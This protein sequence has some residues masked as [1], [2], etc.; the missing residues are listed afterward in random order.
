MR[1]I[2]ALAAPAIGLAVLTLAAAPSWAADCAFEARVWASVSSSY[3]NGAR[4][5]DRYKD[6]KTGQPGRVITLFRSPPALKLIADPAVFGDPSWPETQ[7]LV[8]AL[9]ARLRIEHA[10]LTDK[11]R[12]LSSRAKLCN[13]DYDALTASWRPAWQAWASAASALNERKSAE[14]RATAR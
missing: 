1:S 9:N 7:A 5:G 11:A 3:D 10:I 12:A 2:I 4:N 13:A 14:R 6:L 8:A